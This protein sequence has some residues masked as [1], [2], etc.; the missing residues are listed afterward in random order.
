MLLEGLDEIIKKL[1]RSPIYKSSGDGETHHMGR[2]VIYTLLPHRDPF[3]LVDA[4]DA[5]DREKRIIRG[6]KH[7]Q[8]T[9]PV[10]V[11]H[12]PENPVYPGVLQVE[13][14]GQLALCLVRLINTDG[15]DESSLNIRAIK[16][17]HA[18]YM[19]PV[20]P[21]YDLAIHACVIEDNGITAICAGQIYSGSTLC[22]CCVQEVYFVE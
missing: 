18:V 10:F 3:L 11:G 16:I 5:L 13:A 9:D 7:I 21:E 22:S 8:K 4:I 12:F 19:A 15:M 6:V 20:Y 2:D 17:H 1:R 14:M